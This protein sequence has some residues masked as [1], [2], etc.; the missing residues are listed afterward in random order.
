MPQPSFPRNPPT[1]P[2]FH[3][4]ITQRSGDD[5]LIVLGEE[6]RSYRQAEARSAALAHA[7]LEA[8][9]GKGTRVG[10]LF[11]NGPAWLEH[12]MAL[13]RIG[14][15]A[16]P[17]NT[18]YQARELA[19]T[20]DHADIEVLVTIDRFLQHDYLERLEAAVPGLSQQAGSTLALAALPFLRR[21]FV[22][23]GE[24]DPPAS[25]PAWCS[26]LAPAQ[27]FD[28]ARLEAAEARVEPADAMMIL[29]SS[30]STADPKGAV[31]SHGTV[32]R[33][34]HNLLA[35]RDVVASDRVWSPMP[36]FWVGG[37]VFSLLGC[38]HAGA[39]L[40]CEEA[41]DPERTLARFEHE[42]VTIAAGW[43]HFGQ[44]LANHPSAGKRDLAALRAGNLPELLP[45]HVVSPDP[46]L[47]PNAL[48]MTETCGPHTCVSEGPLPESLRGSHGV[49]VPGVEHK[50]VDPATGEPLAP[51]EDGEICVRG[52]SLMQRLYK[53]EREATFDADGF[54]HTGDVGHF[55]EQGVL[56]FR[57]RL[58]DMI[59]TGGANVTPSE[60]EQVIAGRP[61]V[62]QCYVVGIPDPDRGQ[63]VVA[64]VVAEP[65]ASVDP[66]ALRAHV[67]SELAAYKVPRHVFVE[68]EKALPFTASGKL[69]K[70]RLA[71]ALGERLDATG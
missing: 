6:R 53:V 19:W 48:G 33:H 70:Q 52:Y 5:P 21:I 71:A 16:V 43:P 10:L 45:E 40:I 24:A 69:D 9:I 37:F 39:C 46:E 8:G 3:R 12:W 22:E 18:F 42:R 62:A 63:L 23:A 36:F 31:H 30:G 54:Y 13:T 14:A 11:P 57:G 20:L 38:L 47:R 66:E 60:V 27:D 25:L 17:F 64:A 55:D 51:G 61:E 58:G 2:H 32:L 44:A 41:F 29:Y 67:K 34:S 50:I 7:M 4:A 35:T 26:G 68:D 15:I 56:Y 59:K 28:P 49:A 1:T 65:N